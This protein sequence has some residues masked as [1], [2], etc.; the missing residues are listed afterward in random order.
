MSRQ[1]VQARFKLIVIGEAKP[2]PAS[3]REVACDRAM[4]VDQYRGAAE[5]GFHQ[6]DGKALV[7]RRIAKGLR[8]RET[9]IFVLRS[10]VAQITDV[11][12]VRRLLT[13]S[14]QKQLEPGR[15]SVA[16]V[17][18]E[19]GEQQVGVLGPVLS[20]DVEKE[21]R[22]LQELAPERL[23]VTGNVQ[24]ESHA[25]DDLAGGGNPVES[26]SQPLF[27]MGVEDPGLNGGKALPGESHAS[28]RLVMKTGDQDG[29]VAGGGDPVVGRSVEVGDE[30]EEVVR[31]L[32]FDELDEG[33]AV[34]AFFEESLFLFEADGKA[35]QEF[36]VHE[37]EGVVVAGAQGETADG[38]AAVAVDA[39]AVVGDVPVALEFFDGRGQNFDL[40]ASFGE[41]MSPVATE[42]FGPSGDLGAVPGDYEGEFGGHN[43]TMALPYGRG[44]DGVRP[45]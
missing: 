40:F 41:M 22:L 37:V 38:Y 23:G 9:V 7:Y 36:A 25:Q 6:D 28:I 1:V 3:L 42:V 43:T 11:R 26:L 32:F 35:R 5:P 39:G 19:V 13:Y 44:S 30:E 45:D 21:G 16:L 10:Q 18:L 12:T 20:A 33:I 31:A 24:G 4:A 17:F 27:G 14:G 8:R 29:A 34:H 2:T 15:E